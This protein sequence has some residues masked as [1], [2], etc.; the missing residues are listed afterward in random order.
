MPE[1]LRVILAEIDAISARIFAEP[2]SRFHSQCSSSSS[3]D[4]CIAHHFAAVYGVSKTPEK[5]VENGTKW[6][7]DDA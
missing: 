5:V 1:R 3:F 7:L 6:L 2:E 4:V